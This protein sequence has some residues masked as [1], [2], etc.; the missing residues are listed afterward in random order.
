[1]SVSEPFTMHEKMKQKQQ[2]ANKTGPMRNL[3]PIPKRMTS[4][5][6]SAKRLDWKGPKVIPGEFV[7]YR[8]HGANEEFPA[9]TTKMSNQTYTVYYFRPMHGVKEASSVAYHDHTGKPEGNDP[10][11]CFCQNGTIRKTIFGAAVEYLMGTVDSAMPDGVSDIEKI[12]AEV[13]ALRGEVGKLLA[14]KA[15]NKKGD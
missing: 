15:G 14:T 6:A 2:E 4:A 8:P 10:M 1:M 9:F 11:A 7:F 13:D 3:P 5:E 12:K